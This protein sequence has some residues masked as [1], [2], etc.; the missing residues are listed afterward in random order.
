M[1]CPLCQFKLFFLFMVLLAACTSPPGPTDVP[2]TPL[3]I[4]FPQLI[5]A[6]VERPY[7][8]ALVQGTL[9]IVDDCLRVQVREGD[10]SYLIIW[11]PHVVLNITGDAIQVVDQESQ[12][13]AQVGEA[14]EL[15]GGETPS[16]TYLVEELREPLPATCP[17]PY[18]LA[19]G[20]VP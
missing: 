19:S 6:N 11:P 9:V 16:A 5:P 18:W 13:V 2:V 17:G 3:P 4:F 1:K 20:I 15:G 14:V 12:A 10:T 8:D 7:L